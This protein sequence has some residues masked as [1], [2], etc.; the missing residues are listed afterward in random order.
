LEADNYE[1]MLEAYGVKTKLFQESV[2]KNY[3]YPMNVGRFALVEIYIRTSDLPL[4]K[5]LI[6]DLENKSKNEED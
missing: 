6:K 3:G 4:A 5:D 1:S 2:G